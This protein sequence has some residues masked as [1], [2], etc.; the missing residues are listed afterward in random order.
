LQNNNANKL[1]IFLLPQYTHENFYIQEIELEAGAVKIVKLLDDLFHWIK[2]LKS[3]NAST[4]SS[5]TLSV[6]EVG[7]KN[8]LEF[9]AKVI[10]SIIDILLILL[11]I[12]LIY[13]LLIYYYY[14]FIRLLLLHL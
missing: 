4:S 10:I 11:I 8:I 5:K 13:Q 2:K 1:N 3:E 9:K 12:L 7:Q 6:D 14:L